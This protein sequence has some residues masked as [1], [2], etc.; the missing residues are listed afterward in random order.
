MIVASHGFKLERCGASLGNSSR[1][2]GDEGGGNAVD[3]AVAAGL[4]LGVGMGSTR[5][6]VAMLSDSHTT[7]EI[8]GIDGR[9]AAPA[10]A[11][12]DMYLKTARRIHLCLRVGRLP[13][14]FLAPSLRM[15]W[16]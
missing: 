7:S 6:L 5:E 4:T 3:A 8:V 9:E 12:R 2:G 16:P 1:D 13:L 11:H 10:T 15:N 14:L